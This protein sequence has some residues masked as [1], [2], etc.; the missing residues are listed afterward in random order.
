MWFLFFNF[1]IQRLAPQPYK[2]T[3]HTLALLDPGI[4]KWGGGG[5]LFAPA[6][7]LTFVSEPIE[8]PW[9]NFTHWL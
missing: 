1:K 8:T 6:G 5:S 2:G 7:L 3:G 9:L 4:L